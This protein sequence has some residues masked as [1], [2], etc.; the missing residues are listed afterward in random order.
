M[1]LKYL[2][3]LFTTEQIY[4][5]YDNKCEIL[6]A[7]LCGIQCITAAVINPETAVQRVY[8]ATVYKHL[9]YGSAIY[10]VSLHNAIWRAL[11]HPL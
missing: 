3:P 4:I 10:I 6:L 9:Q 5:Q 1:A 11:W 8:V 2:S 7:A